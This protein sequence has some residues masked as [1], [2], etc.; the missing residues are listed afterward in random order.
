MELTPEEKNLTVRILDM[1]VDT[2]IEYSDGRE[3]SPQIIMAVEELIIIKSVLLKID[4][5]IV[6]SPNS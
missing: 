2:L 6:L 4:E 5:D 1:Y 3:P